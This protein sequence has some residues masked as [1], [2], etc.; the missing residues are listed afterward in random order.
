MALADAGGDSF[1]LF[2]VPRGENHM[3]AVRGEPIRDRFT[4]AAGSAR[5]EGTRERRI[6]ARRESLELYLTGQRTPRGGAE[7]IR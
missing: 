3:G 7:P 2:G 4:D 5:H 6:R 1:E